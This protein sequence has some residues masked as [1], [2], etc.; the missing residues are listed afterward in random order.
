M[1]VH[2]RIQSEQHSNRSIHWTQQ[3]AVLNRVNDFSLQSKLPQ[4]SIK[5]LQLTSLLPDKRV[6]QRLKQKWT[7]LVSRVVCRFLP[8]FQ[9]LRDVVIWHIDHPY[10]EQMSSKS[11][12]VSFNV[13]TISR[14]IYII[15]M[16]DYH[17]FWVT[18]GCFLNSH[19]VMNVLSINLVCCR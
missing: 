9:P 4:K 11:Q 18:L 6:R 19:A 3:Y 10:T 15:F 14:V 2:A 8:K 13:M 17:H 5:D 7:V 12:T 1:M 16:V